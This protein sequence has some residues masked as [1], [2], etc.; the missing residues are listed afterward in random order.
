MTAAPV[1]ALDPVWVE[2]SLAAEASAR[3]VR[4][5]ARRELLDRV[6]QRRA[7]IRAAEADELVAITEWADLH[8]TDAAHDLI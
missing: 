7:D 5:C 1:A 6:A 8:R 3:V 2:A 4:S